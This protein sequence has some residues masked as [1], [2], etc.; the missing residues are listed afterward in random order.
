MSSN[1]S[2]LDETKATEQQDT[3]QTKK[4]ITKAIFPTSDILD[5]TRQEKF[6]DDLEFAAFNYIEPTSQ[7]ATGTVKTNP[8][9]RSQFLS[10]QIRYMDAGIS[11]EVGS[12]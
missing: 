9:K 11:C 2:V 3:K 12:M 4:W 7:G 5:E 8:L 1:I 10:D 6:I